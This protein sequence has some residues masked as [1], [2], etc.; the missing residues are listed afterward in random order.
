MKKNM[1]ALAAVMMIAITGT[2]A[3]GI[4]AEKISTPDGSIN[5]LVGFSP[6]S[7]QT[8]TKSD[9]SSY[10]TAKLVLINDKT[11]KSFD[12]S[13]Y[14]VYVLTKNGKLM[15]NYTT[16]AESGE[17]ACTY[18]LKPGDSR[19]QIV[20]FSNTFQPAEVERVWLVFSDDISFE[21][22]YAKD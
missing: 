20:C 10:C 16:S 2:F 18:T 17:Y 11:A 5:F 13:D 6:E 14:K 9:G 3:Q 8:I 12:W 7:L 22:I 1:I 15:Y 19:T 4:F 21:L